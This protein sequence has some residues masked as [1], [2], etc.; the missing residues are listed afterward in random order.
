MSA[1]ARWYERNGMFC[2]AGVTGPDAS[3]KGVHSLRLLVYYTRIV[4]TVF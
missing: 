1:F 4:M 3:K 2:L